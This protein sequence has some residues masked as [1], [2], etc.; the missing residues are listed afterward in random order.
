M[1]GKKQAGYKASRQQKPTRETEAEKHKCQV[2]GVGG[3]EG[4]LRTWTKLF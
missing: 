4:I 1:F 3:G 2:L